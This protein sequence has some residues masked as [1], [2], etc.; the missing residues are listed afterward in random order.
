M[1]RHQLDKVD[2]TLLHILQES[3]RCK[4][5]ELAEA[6]DLSIPSVSE[7]LKKLEESGFIRGYRA[8]LDPELMGFGIMAFIVV[9]VDSSGNYPSFIDH[10]RRL[11]EIAECHA[12]T[13]EG[14]HMLKVRTKTTSDLE[15]LLSEIQSWEGVTKTTTRVALSSPKES[16]KVPVGDLHKKL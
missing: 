8:I 5:N 14:T 7:R 3:G 16:T 9:T 2:R 11:D 15:R 13:G 4:R 12:I 6:T 1:N 10:V